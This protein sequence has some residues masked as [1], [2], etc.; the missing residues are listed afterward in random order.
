MYPTE[1][2]IC[3]G[4]CFIST[5]S[6]GVVPIYTVRVPCERGFLLLLCM[7]LLLTEYLHVACVPALR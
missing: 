4:Y 5:F 2:L 7:P 3:R 1:T 6:K